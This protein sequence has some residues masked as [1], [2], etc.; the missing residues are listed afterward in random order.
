MKS[1]EVEAAPKKAYWQG[2][3]QSWKQSGL[4][5]AIFC[6]D[7]SLALSTFAYWRRKIKQEGKDRPRFFPLA[8]VPS[9]ESRN[10]CQAHRLRL[11][12]GDKRFLL[13]I[14]DDFSEQTLKRLVVALE[15]L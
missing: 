11:I 2:H 6:K 8:L 13:E 1:N 12:L 10:K 4:S 14:D 9:P 7:Q 15:Q 3:I 5:Q